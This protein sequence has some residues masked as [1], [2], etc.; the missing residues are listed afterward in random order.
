MQYLGHIFCYK[1]N[2]SRIVKWGQLLDSIYDFKQSNEHV[3]QQCKQ[4]HFTLL[5]SSNNIGFVTPSN[6]LKYG[7]KVVFLFQSF[8]V[9]TAPQFLTEQ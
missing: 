7:Y 4:S 6:T 9:I 1:K 2:K 8:L 3:T 5:V